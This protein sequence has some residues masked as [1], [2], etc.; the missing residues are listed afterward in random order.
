KSRLALALLAWQKPHLLLL[1]EPTN[2]LDLDMRDALTL[3]LEEYTGAVVLVS[4]DRSLI[5][6]VADE[7]WLVADGAV[8]LFDGDLEDYKSWIETRRSSAAA[9]LPQPEK[10]RR[11]HAPKPNRKA[12]QSKQGKL[13]TALATAQAEL[14]AVSRQLADPATYADSD[15]DKISQLNARHASLEAKVAELEESWLELE[16]AMEEGG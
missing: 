13:E 7:L 16:M 14:A 8:R 9:A 1:D 6:A 12:L 15:R 11:E 10:P 3:A 2:H 5:R 4:H